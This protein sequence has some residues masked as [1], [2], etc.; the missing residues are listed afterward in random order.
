MGAALCSL[1]FRNIAAETECEAEANAGS[2]VPRV[3]M[4]AIPPPN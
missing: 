1:V 4:G 2:G 3:A